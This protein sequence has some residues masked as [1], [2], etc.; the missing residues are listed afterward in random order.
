[1][2]KKFAWNNSNTTGMSDILMRGNTL[3]R[4]PASTDSFCNGLLLIF[5]EQN[6][7]FSSLQCMDAVMTNKKEAYLK[8]NCKIIIVLDQNIVNKA[9]G[10]R[11]K[12]ILEMN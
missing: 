12:L 10:K 6:G 4:I 5:L 1:M 11:T 7:S 9:Q 3:S 8:M 2:M